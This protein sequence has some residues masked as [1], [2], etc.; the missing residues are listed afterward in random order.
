MPECLSV[1]A[2]TSSSCASPTD[3][4]SVAKEISVVRHFGISH[5]EGYS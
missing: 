3:L 1:A 4:C 2:T 5:L